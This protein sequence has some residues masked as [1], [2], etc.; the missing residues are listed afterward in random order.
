MIA[1]LGTSR[2]PV[3]F[4]TLPTHQTCGKKRDQQKPA[5]LTC[6]FLIKTRI[7][8][9]NP[10]IAIYSTGVD[11]LPLEPENPIRKQAIGARMG[12]RIVYLSEQVKLPGSWFCLTCSGPPVHANTPGV[13]DR[14]WP[15]RHQNGAHFEEIQKSKPVKC[16]EQVFLGSEL[17]PFFEWEITNI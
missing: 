16:P 11:A 2:H 8:A 4:H 9:N 5:K 7:S 13:F 3:A 1:L 15:R 14:T 12:L 17:T 6:F 10:I